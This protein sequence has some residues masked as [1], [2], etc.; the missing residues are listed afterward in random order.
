MTK[1]SNKRRLLFSLFTLVAL[2]VVAYFT[3]KQKG[4]FDNGS[5]PGDMPQSDFNIQDTTS[6]DKMIITKTTGEKA[7][8]TRNAKGEWMI[9]GKYKARPDA[10]NL[11]MHTLQNVKVK[12][13]VGN[14]ARNSVIRNIAVYHRKIQFFSKG[15][16]IKTW[17]VGNPTS[18][19]I[20]TYFLLETPEGGK[21]SE[22]YIMDL[23]R[24]HGQ[25]DTRFFT[26]EEDWRYTGIFNYSPKDIKEIKL[27]NREKPGDGFTLRMTAGNKME[28]F[29]NMGGKI[30]GF[31]TLTARA[32]TYGYKKI[33]FEHV[34]KRL[35]YESLDS[36]K[37]TTPFYSITVTDAANQ[38]NKIDLYQMKNHDKVADFSGKIYEWNPSRLYAI[39][40]TG[41]A[42]VVQYY[43]I[44][45][46]L[47][48]VSVFMRAT[49]AAK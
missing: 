22:P 47:R 30:N 2:L 9:N 18:D 21:S 43:S 1:N 38:V 10:I 17:Y 39:L 8:L 34:A 46:I 31:D 14:A 13:R 28:L 5:T 35:S 29:D 4:W 48:P 25:L 36:M 23:A 33:H 19:R 49:P 42:V 45:K 41:E 6:L 11:I 32:Y 15:Q 20:G 7:E 37:K 12:A 24:F 44:D 26:E 3:A 16:W 40:P 27:T